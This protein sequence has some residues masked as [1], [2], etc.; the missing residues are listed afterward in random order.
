MPFADDDKI[1]I[2]EFLISLCWPVVVPVLGM[3]A[4]F[5]VI[6]N[7]IFMEEDID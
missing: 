3:Y 2:K 1:F 4:I 5:K 6:S 7:N